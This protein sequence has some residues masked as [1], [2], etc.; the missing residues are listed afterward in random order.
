MSTHP[1][2]GAVSMW[3]GWRAK[4]ECVLPAPSPCCLQPS[5]AP[6]SL[7]SATHI[8]AALGSATWPWHGDWSDRFHRTHEQQEL[9][10]GRPKEAVLS[11]PPHPQPPFPTCPK[12]SCMGSWKAQVPGTPVPHSAAY[13]AGGHG[14]VPFSSWPSVSSSV[15]G[16]FGISNSAHSRILG[17]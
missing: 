4:D 3:P 5:Y 12:S 1:G 10:Q 7:G 14:Q 2:P 8:P 15:Q 9:G 17:C 13:S 16:G 6:A 11:L